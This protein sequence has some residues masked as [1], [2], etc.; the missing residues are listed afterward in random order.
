MVLAVPKALPQIYIFLLVIIS[1]VNIFM[2]SRYDPLTLSFHH[3]RRPLPCLDVRS[4]I[5]LLQED[6]DQ[7]LG[8]SRCLCCQASEVAPA[9]ATEP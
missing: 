3:N 7:R 8:W 4:E 2:S 5:V 9:N 6:Q 1:I